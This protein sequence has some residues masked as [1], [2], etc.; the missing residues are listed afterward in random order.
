MALRVCAGEAHVGNL[1]K[2]RPLSEG[3]EHPTSLDSNIHPSVIKE[4]AKRMN[5]LS[6]C[7]ETVL[8]LMGVVCPCEQ[9]LYSNV[10]RGVMA[11]S[12]ASCMCPRVRCA[13]ASS[14]EQ[15]QSRVVG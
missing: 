10:R 4:L 7:P 13:E 15:G 9:S 5:I 1:R 8:R 2:I 14:C 3:E 11:S 12:A 6:F